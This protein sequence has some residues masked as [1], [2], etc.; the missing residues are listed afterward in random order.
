MM[1]TPEIE[2]LSDQHTLCGEAPLW[3]AAGKCVYWVDIE[4]SIIFKYRFADSSTSIVSR[5]VVACGL[6]MND[7]GRLVAAGMRGLHLV[8]ESGNVTPVLESSVNGDFCFNDLTAAPNGK[9]YAGTF[10]WED[11]TMLRYGRLY[12]IDRDG[13]PRVVDEGIQL[14]NGL[15]LSP[16]NRTLYY[17][18]SV[19]RSIYA[20]DVAVES[21]DLRNKRS[22]AALPVEEGVPD[23]LTVDA[24]GFVWC[25]TWYGGQVLRFDPD[26][27][28]ERRVKLPVK[29]TSSVTFGGTELTDL[30]VTS[31]A[32]YWKS[33]YEPPGFDSS[34]PMGGGLYRVRLPIRGKA[35]FRCS[36]GM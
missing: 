12:L 36:L 2:L 13:R 21:G 3:D 33:P 9:L 4:K 15:G 27:S 22:F 20:Y 25:A 7:D 17:A 30:F 18:D 35:E 16:D 26:G 19:A 6:A 28:I 10:H 1:S 24:D 29:Q 8:S 14:S 5:D 11:V 34:T 32:Q 31:G 23:G